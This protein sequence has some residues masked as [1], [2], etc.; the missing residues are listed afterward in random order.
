MNF[1]HI[2][3]N[4]I[5]G[6]YFSFPFVCRKPSKK[7][8]KSGLRIRN[9]WIYR[10]KMFAKQ[11]V[12][13]CHLEFCWNYVKLNCTELGCAVKYKLLSTKFSLLLTDTQRLSLL[14]CW[15]W[16]SV[17]ICA[18]DWRWKDISTLVWQGMCVSLLNKIHFNIQ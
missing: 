7:Q 13:S 10:E 11:W 17:R 1:F 9:L 18:C 8:E 15:F 16:S 6:S 12:D 4:L 2:Y 14:Q 5:N 3:L